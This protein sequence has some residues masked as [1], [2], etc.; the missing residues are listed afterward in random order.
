M[1]FKLNGLWPFKHH[2][3]WFKFS[4]NLAFLHNGF[5]SVSGNSREACFVKFK[6]R[7]LIC[8][9]K[10][11]NRL[12]SKQLMA[13]PFFP[14]TGDALHSLR[15]NLED[16]NNVLQSWDPT[17]VNPCTWFHVT[18][19]NENSVI[20]V[21]VVSLTSTKKMLLYYSSRE[22]FNW[23][24]FVLCLIP[25]TLEMHSCRVN[26]F[27]SS[28]FLRIYNICKLL[29]ASILCCWLSFFSKCC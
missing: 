24:C 19:N 22:E 13:F 29:C 18:C 20:R 21:Y 16:P 28:A 11:V 25:V 10:C 17:L 23:Q 6:H 7:C 5:V 4:C 26:L 9:V 14:Q 8:Y 3:C 27:H 1:V 12:Y 2:M 15:T